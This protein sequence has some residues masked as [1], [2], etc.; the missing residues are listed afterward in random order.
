M[1]MLVFV[2]RRAFARGEAR[3]VSGRWVPLM[4]T[5]ALME[6]TWA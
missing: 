2:R 4:T 6:A 5:S 3:V 1:R